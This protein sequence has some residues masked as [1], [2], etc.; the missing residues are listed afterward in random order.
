MHVLWFKRD[1]RVSDHQPLREVAARSTQGG[2]PALCLYV[3]EPSYWTAP[4]ADGRHLDFVLE[5]L[6]EL[7]RA[8]AE[9]GAALV[10]K[11]GEMPDVLVEL[12]RAHPLSGLWSHRETGNALTFARD[13]R[14]KAW[15]DAHGV[16]W[17][18]RG[19]DGAVRRLGS[20]DGWSKRWFRRMTRPLLAP[21]DR[22]ETAAI[23]SDAWPSAESLGVTRGVPALIDRQPG[24]ESQGQAVLRSFL[25]ERGVD[26]RR[27]MSSPVDG[28][29]GCSRLSPHLAWGNVSMRRV[30][31]SGRRR[32]EWV[33]EQKRR[34][35]PVDPRWAK[36]LDAF[37]S[38]LQWHCHFMQKLE[39]EPS[40]EFEN[41]NRAFDGLR[42]GDFN[43]R[44]F[45][46]W[47]RGETGVPMVDA[48]MR[49][50]RQTGWMNFRMRAMLVSFASYDLWL[51][52]R[53]PAL[54]LARLFTDYEPGIHYSQ[55]QMQAGTTG[56]NAMRVY[57]PVKQQRDQDP[58]GT[59][60]RR[61]VPELEA[62]PLTHLAE[63]HKMGGLEQRSV[64]CVIG[65]DYPEPVVDLRSAS[66][67]AKEK[68]ARAR[69]SPAV[70]R[71]ASRV[72]DKHGSRRPPQQRM[73]RR[74]SS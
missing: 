27:A 37:T 1:L 47:R 48:T 72:L 41:M 63:P 19:Q 9:R 32:L 53:E 10:V 6:V 55:I 22:I 58:A 31:Q 65:R 71:A 7:N 56:I 51:H 17:T 30:Y 67:V 42:E 11:V 73:R 38:R 54:H 2:A 20:R 69:K 44:S 43:P 24:G 18:E 74:T 59:F 5:S 13:R 23:A 16:P 60:V 70:K 12:H 64:G 15:C 21:P 34:G 28:W 61:W 3:F 46:A 52:W 45:E 25:K 36:S 4:D 49:C 50:L 35:K 29:E 26:Y 68:M 8:L 33:K 62:V 40:I 66:R 57:S 14:V 39:S